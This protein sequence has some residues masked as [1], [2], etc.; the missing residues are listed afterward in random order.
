ML[1]MD[2]LAEEPPR[3]QSGFGRPDSRTHLTNGKRNKDFINQTR[4]EPITASLR[5][6]G[7]AGRAARAEISLLQSP[8]SLCLEQQPPNSDLLSLPCSREKPLRISGRQSPRPEGAG[9]QIAQQFPLQGMNEIIII[10][11]KTNT[12]SEEHQVLPKISLLQI[13]PNIFIF[14]LLK[15]PRAWVTLPD[16]CPSPN[17]LLW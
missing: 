1:K 2:G 6:S 7:L 17:P 5:S 10:I 12:Q 14:H 15:N 4:S 3:Q 8:C 9:S 11:K 13:M 16:L